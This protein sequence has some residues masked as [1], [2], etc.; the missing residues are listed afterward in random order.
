M[1][2]DVKLVVAISV[3]RVDEVAAHAVLGLPDRDAVAQEECDKAQNKS[4]RHNQPKSLRPTFTDTSGPSPRQLRCPL[5]AK[6][7]HSAVT[8]QD[9][10]VCVAMITAAANAVMIDPIPN[11]RSA[12]NKWLYSRSLQLNKFATDDRATAD[13][14]GFSTTDSFGAVIA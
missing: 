13:P 9:S 6:S 4:W 1:P 11:I 7:G 8:S 2:V 3:D 5:S 14:N 10:A 12:A